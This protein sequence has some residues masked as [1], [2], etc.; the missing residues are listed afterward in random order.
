MGDLLL[1]YIPLIILHTAMLSDIYTLYVRRFNVGFSTQKWSI[2]D[3]IYW[4][5]HKIGS[6]YRCRNDVSNSPS[7]QFAFLTK[8][9]RHFD[10]GYRRVQH[11]NPPVRPGRAVCWGGRAPRVARPSV[12][13]AKKKKLKKKRFSNFLFLIF[14]FFVPVLV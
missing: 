9:W 4:F 14:N 6:K 3:D 8:N 2:N 11:H 12:G 5:R 1:L 7:F 10:I 13:Q